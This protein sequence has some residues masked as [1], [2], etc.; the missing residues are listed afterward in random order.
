M[1]VERRRIEL[2]YSPRAEFLPFHNRIQRWACL[3]AHRRAG[4]TVATINDVIKRAITENRPDGRYA[5][6]APLYN[7]SK[8]VA[9]SY[10]KKYAGPLLAGSPNETEL[11]VDLI[12]GARIRLYGADSPDRLR[13]LYLDGCVL[14][15]YGDMRPAMWTDVIRPALSDRR[16]WAV[17][18]GTPKGKN[19]FYEIM[20]GSTEF[21]GAVNDP[22]WYAL[23][24]KASDTSLIAPA[25]LAD[26]R[27]QMGEDRYLQEYECSFDAAIQGAYYADALRRAEAESRIGRIPIDRGIPVHTAWDL[28]LS[29]S[30]AIW[31]IQCVAKERRLIDYYEGSGV[32][33]DHYAAV[34][35]EKGYVY[36]RHYFPHDVSVHELGSG[37]SRVDTLRGLGIVAEVGEAANVED[38]INATRR[39]LD[40]CWID[41]ERCARG[42][43]A[44]KSYRREYDDRL[45]DWKNRPLHDWASHG[46]DALRTFATGFE[47]RAALKP[48]NVSPRGA[49][50]WMGG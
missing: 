23:T 7:Q 46:A 9:W 48:L 15:E 22:D 6:I 19:S 41:S 43:E 5:Y 21:R 2:D 13:G 24:L 11:R 45:K 44:L 27:K 40:Q 30:T 38:G 39:L 3:V 10:L 8:D 32:G 31:F 20:H 36:G 14:D 33:L 18:I 42:L 4:K 47:D 26:A 35:K 16:G 37:K 34:L 17:F 49:G 1:E 25:E 29:D 28:G 50:S 12:N